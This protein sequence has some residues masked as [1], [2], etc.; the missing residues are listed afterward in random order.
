VGERGRAR[1]ILAAIAATVATLALAAPA[2][3]AEPVTASGDALRSGWYPDQPGLSPAVVTGGSFGKLFETPVQGQ[4]YA[5]PL[6][7]DGTLLV[8]T[9]DNWIYGLGPVDGAVRWA[10]NVGT[11][12]LASEISGCTDLVP[13]VGI[14]G[15]PVIDPD[16]GLAYFLAKTYSAPKT[17]IWEMH[18]V[19]MASGQEA[20]GFPVKISGAAEN[21]AGINF[22]AKQELQRPGLLLMDGVVYAGFGSHCDNQPYQGWLIG[23][24]TAGQIRTR[25]ATG[26]DGSAIWQAGGGLISDGPNQI[27]FAT[28][29]SFEPTPPNSP[30]PPSDLGEAVGR[31][32]IGPNGA[33]TATDFFSPFNRK[34][35]DEKDLDLGSS[36]PIALP[37]QYFGT[38]SVP[39]LLLVGGKEHKIFVLDRDD[40]GGQGQGPGGKNNVVQEI[41]NAHAVFGSMAIW[42]GQGGYVYVP[43]ILPGS[44]GGIEILKYG[45][46]AGQPRFTL[47]GQTPDP[48]QFGSG[49]PIVTSDGTTPGSAI[50]WVPQ[51]A[52]ASSCTTSSLNAYRAVPSEG[53][54]LLW[55]SPIGVSPKFGRPGVAG[56][57]VYVGTRDNRVIGFGAPEAAGGSP[58]GA[59]GAG[60]GSGSSS[61]PPPL[62][63]PV[64]PVPQTR[65]RAADLQ[66]AKGIA[67]FRFSGSGEPERFECRLL[68]P[69]GAKAAASAKSRAFRRCSSPR[70]YRHL[71]PGAYTF[72]V[73]AA[74][75]AGADPTPAKRHFQF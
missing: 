20:P 74:N 4:V 38:P 15:T 11:P 67:S 60:F 42:P 23:V 37:S 9:E 12:F 52:N 40:L 47:I 56:G 5:Q 55:K 48:L 27:L 63:P 30:T 3:A 64:P 58:G 43:G 71:G 68:R 2:P 50:V 26:P 49:S 45:T 29:N 24:S 19:S 14:T 73:R 32:E 35:L 51:C 1:S 7:A 57:R 31:V 75:A 18:A 44:T 17:P 10:R 16:T 54:A 65:I 53:S 41:A 22:N 59:A 61:V 25:W 62:P 70:V 46:E 36:S 39:N 69:A 21:L 28:G 33:A 8:V 66:P 72:E 34:E 13:N 6:V